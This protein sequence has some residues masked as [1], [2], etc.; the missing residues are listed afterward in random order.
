MTLAD[1]GWRINLVCCTPVILNEIE[2]GVARK[3]VALTYA[4]A[5]KSE[6][7]GADKPD[8][9]A[10]N[11]AIIAKW[12]IKGLSALKNRAWGILQGKIDPSK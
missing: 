2:K 7:Q 10:I 11:Q 12:G 5:M 8:W 9:K 3:H 6:V 1:E 4:M